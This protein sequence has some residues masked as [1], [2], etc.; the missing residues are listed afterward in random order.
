MNKIVI[1][2]GSNNSGKTTT[3]R[4]FFKIKDTDGS[5]SS[6]IH[7]KINGK[8]LCAVS[9]SSPQE[10]SMF[11][12][13]KQVQDDINERIQV[14][15]DESKGKPYILLIPFTM[16]GSRTKKKKLNEECI[17]KPIEEL[18]RKFKVYVIYLRKTNA[19]N[20]IE[21]DA[22]MKKINAEPEPVETTRTDYDKSEELEKFLKKKIAKP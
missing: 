22:L 10:R 1:L 12:N 15:D 11:C 18:K 17:I 4:G 9:F 21:K 14:C 6:Y 8:I 19:R 13:V 16:S 7:R 5:P 20:P 2:C 3:L